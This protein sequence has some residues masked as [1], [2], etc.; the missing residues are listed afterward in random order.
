M[1]TLY[2]VVIYGCANVI[3]NF[4]Y[5]SSINSLAWQSNKLA[6][7]NSGHLP[8]KQYKIIEECQSEIEKVGA[9][10]ESEFNPNSFDPTFLHPQI[11]LLKELSRMDSLVRR[12]ND[13]NV[14]RAKEVRDYVYSKNFKTIQVLDDIPFG[15]YDSIRSMIIDLTI[16][17]DR[18]ATTNRELTEY[19]NRNIFIEGLMNFHSFDH[20]NPLG[21]E[22]RFYTICQPKKFYT[23][24]DY[25][26]D[27][28]F[29]I[30]L[31]NH[32]PEVSEDYYFNQIPWKRKA[33]LI[34][35]SL[36]SKDS[37]YTYLKIDLD[38]VNVEALTYKLGKQ[39]NL[40]EK[41][42]AEIL[43]H[44]INYLNMNT[45]AGAG[46]FVWSKKPIGASSNS[47]QPFNLFFSTRLDTIRNFPYQKLKTQPYMEG[48]LQTFSGLGG[49][50]DLGYG[51]RFPKIL[52][53]TISLA[54]KIFV[55]GS[56]MNTE[57]WSYDGNYIKSFTEV[58]TGIICGPNFQYR[59]TQFGV[60]F[61]GS[62]SMP[63]I[64]RT[65]KFIDDAK[66]DI[67]LPVETQSYDAK[68]IMLYFTLKQIRFCGG[69]KLYSLDDTTLKFDRYNTLIYAQLQLRLNKN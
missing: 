27:S 65:Y 54:G 21:L 25:R 61:G 69:C 49:M 1:H 9:I 7:L 57:P 6:K 46:V 16:L 55:Q 60:H 13:L 18:L 66:Q 39:L 45:Y 30:N 56:I 63:S 12:S 23:T 47:Y 48:T 34:K 11:I 68:Q 28:T 8:S 42:L 5:H 38:H 24:N 33:E 52:F 29:V 17:N 10:V 20:P 44:K 53:K 41:S 67:F 40:D 19:R 15:Y 51:Y 64:H 2:K 62:W 26:R 31:L 58:E 4:R 32:F 59:N 22:S 43:A 36:M 35:N 50:I 37:L 3:S 14:A